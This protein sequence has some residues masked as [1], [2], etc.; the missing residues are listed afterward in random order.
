MD[1]Y[2]IQLSGSGQISYLTLDWIFSISSVLQSV[3]QQKRGQLQSHNQ[4]RHLADDSSAL[5]PADHG[6][7]TTLFA[8]HALLPPTRITIQ[9]VTRQSVGGSEDVK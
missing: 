6:T 8:F 2:P 9:L 7:M 4:L 5:A 1:G 3:L